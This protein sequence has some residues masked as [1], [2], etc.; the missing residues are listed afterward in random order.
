MKKVFF[1]VLLLVSFAPLFAQQDVVPERTTKFSI[2]V[3]HL[4]TQQQIDNITAKISQLP[5]TSNVSLSFNDYMLVF[6]VK[7]GG[8]YGNFDLT[9]IKDILLFEMAEIVKINRNTIN[10]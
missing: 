7:E 9:K 6:Y 2:K 1:F 8:E 5:Y 3:S 4:K 10:K